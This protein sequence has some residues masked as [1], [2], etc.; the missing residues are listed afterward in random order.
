MKE[1]NNREVAEVPA[2]KYLYYSLCNVS[3]LVTFDMKFCTCFLVFKQ[4]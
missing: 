1:N 4:Y 2:L 3:F